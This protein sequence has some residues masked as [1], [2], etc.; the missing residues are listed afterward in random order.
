[1]IPIGMGLA[2]GAYCLGIFGY[3]MTRGY[4]VT[5]PQMFAQTWPGAQVNA[6]APSDGHSLGIINNNTEVTSPSQLNAEQGQ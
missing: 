6:T 1:V 4:N 5:F 2:F 3:C